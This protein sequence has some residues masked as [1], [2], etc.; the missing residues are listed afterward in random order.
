MKK[1][2]RKVGK[3]VKDAQPVSKP[4][5]LTTSPAPIQS[6]F[7]LSFI[8]RAFLSISPFSSAGA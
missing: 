8:P 3:E 2:E 4:L 1:K 6:Y 5:K 7:F